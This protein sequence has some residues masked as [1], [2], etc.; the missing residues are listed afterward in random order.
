MAE[1]PAEEPRAVL[2]IGYIAR[3]HGIRGEI[4][5]IPHDPASTTLESVERI[6]LGETAYQ[7]LG[8]RPITDGYLLRL[9]GIVDRNAAELLRG[10]TLSVDRSAVP[11]EEGEVFLADLIGYAVQLPDGTAW[12]EIS[13]IEMGFQDRLVIRDGN[14]ERLLPYV[15]EFVGE[16]DTERRIVHVTPPEGLPEER[17]R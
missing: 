10:K 4:C 5:A 15:D 14:V 11:I 13:G 1:K 12:G 17:I 6:Y 7:V 3:A 16:I 8:C 2:E 9:A